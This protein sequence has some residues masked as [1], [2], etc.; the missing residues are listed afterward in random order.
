MAKKPFA[1][2]C[3]KLDVDG[4][5]ERFETIRKS[6]PDV[7]VLGMSVYNRQGMDEVRKTIITL[8]DT[9]KNTKPAVTSKKKKT[10]SAFMAERSVCDTDEIQYPGQEQ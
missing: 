5:Q 4:A 10:V 6:L 1:V 2:V 8:A 9:V 3:N 7:T